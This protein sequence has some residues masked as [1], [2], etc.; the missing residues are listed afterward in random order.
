MKKILAVF[1]ITLLVLFLVASCTNQVSK[2][3]QQNDKPIIQNTTKSNIIL[4]GPLSESYTEGK[5]LIGYEDRNSALEVVKL[6]NGKIAVEV[7]EIKMLSVTFNGKVEDAYKKIKEANI[8]G[9]RYVEPSYKRELIKPEPVKDDPAKYIKSGKELHGTSRGSEYFSSSLWGLEA[10]FGGKSAEEIW[11]EA[12]GTDIIVAVVDTGVDG[13]HPDL[14]G[15]VIKGYRPLTGEE[16][17]EGTDSSYGGSHGTHVAGTIAAKKDGRGIVGVAPNAKI[18][19]IVIFDEDEVYVG[20]DYVAAGIIWAVE[21]GAK[22]MN[23][24]WGGWGYSH[25]MKEAFDYALERNVVMVVSAGN[26][27]TEQHVHYPSGYPGVIQVAAVEYNGGNYRTTWFSNRSDGITVG[28]PGVKICST[29]VMPGSLGYKEH[30][31]YS[32]VDPETNGVYDY[33]DGTSMA[34]PHVTGVVALLLQKFPNAKAWQ[35]RKL[36]ESTAQDIDKAG[37]DTDSGYGLVRADRALEGT[38]P[39]NGGVEFFT[40]EITDAYGEWK[41][42]TVWAQLRRTINNVVVSYYA[43]TDLD[44]IAKFPQIDAGDYE[45]IIGG[46]DSN[47]RC[48]GYS[49][50]MGES[51]PGGYAIN[52]RMAEERQITDNITITTSETKTYAF[53][54]EFKVELPTSLTNEATLVWFDFITSDSDYITISSTNVDLSEKSGLGQLYVMLP[55]TPTELVTLNATVT[56]NGYE[57]PVFTEIG[58]DTTVGILDE[59]GGHPLLYWTVF[60]KK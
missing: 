53:E 6:L 31:G 37:F 51:R 20:D 38:L 59:I 46:P 56:L 3:Q 26:N 11:A 50:A 33:Y 18:M 42:P 48:L 2:P 60:G 15:Q 28:A 32:L 30:Q 54:S 9:I 35:I 41:V 40:V 17:P 24:S 21:N 55:E 14:E 47:E 58:T 43:K 13:T 39:T 25:T 23:H 10:V 29:V 22:V 49:E 45:V 19:P 36:L 12:S 1:S 57:I 52:Y 4:F 34:S 27:H 8:T 44:G 5:V 16:L 7:P